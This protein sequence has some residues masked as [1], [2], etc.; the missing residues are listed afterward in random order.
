LHTEERPAHVDHLPSQEK[1]K[2]RQTHKGCGSCSEDKFTVL[3]L[4]RPFLVATTSQVTV[5]ESPYA[6]REGRQAERCGS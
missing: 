4:F 5:S 3:D 6:D 2:P 1:R